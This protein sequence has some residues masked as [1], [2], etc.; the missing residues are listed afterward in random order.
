MLKGFF[1]TIPPE[2][3]DAARIDGCTRAGAIVRVVLPLARP[4]WR[5]R[6]C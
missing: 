2:L 5:R 4:V 3:E 1:D 6:R